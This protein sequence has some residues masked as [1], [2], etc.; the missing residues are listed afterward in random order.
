[1]TAVERLK[2]KG[3]AVESYVGGA[4][5]CLGVVRSPDGDIVGWQTIDLEELAT[6]YLLNQSPASAGDDDAGAVQLALEAEQEAHA[7][8]RDDLEFELRLNADLLRGRREDDEWRVLARRFLTRWT[9]GSAPPA[10]LSFS[11]GVSML[12]SDDREQHARLREAM[13]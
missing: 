5:G 11:D 13:K 4:G 7:R 10:G 1:M 12:L 9:K 2:A 8:T 6:D 3:Y